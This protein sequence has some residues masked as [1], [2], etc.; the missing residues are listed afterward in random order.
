MSNTRL[1]QFLIKL[2]TRK[3]RNIDRRCS[4]ILVIKL[5]KKFSKWNRHL[6]TSID[7][8]EFVDKLNA[9]IHWTYEI[10][11]KY[12]R[13]CFVVSV[14]PIKEIFIDRIITKN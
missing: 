7:E 2:T 11:D 5:D 14:F 10:S 13:T 12:S 3:A 9:F 8:R 1:V 6:S 4:Q